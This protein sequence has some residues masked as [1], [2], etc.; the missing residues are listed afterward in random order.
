MSGPPSSDGPRA[1]RPVSAALLVTGSAL[2]FAAM[3][4]S[5]KLVSVELS[6]AVVVFFRSLFGLMAALP[7]AGRQAWRR[8]PAR[9]P[10]S[11]HLTRAL[12]GIAAMASYFYAISAL[13]LADAVLL[14]F[15]APLFIPW[16]ARLWLGEAVPRGVAWAA[17]LGFA[18]IALILNPGSGVFRVDAL[19]GVAAGGFAAI[20]MTSVR[21]LTFQESAG[22]I[23]AIYSLLCTLFAAVPLVW[24]WQTPPPASWPILVAMGLF[25]TGGQ[26][27]LTRGYALAPAARVGPFSYLAVIFAALFGW[28]IWDELPG[29]LSLVGAALVCIAGI[30]AIR[31]GGAVDNRGTT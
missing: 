9:A 10:A 1:Q 14:S 21:R 20:A 23:V 25:A 26:L 16:M 3:G 19:A 6:V 7:V 4:A 17:L 5:V 27:L 24:F 12:T 18:G 13:P 11:L 31:R 2:L 28:A 8:G 15:S 22:R 29:P 30:L